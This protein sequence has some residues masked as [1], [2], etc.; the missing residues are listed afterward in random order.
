MTLTVN[1]GPR[2]SGL[3][4]G[5][6]EMPAMMEMASS[7]VDIMAVSSLTMDSMLKAVTLKSLFFR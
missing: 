2:G 7:M 4:D 6:G 1:G 3:A 5:E